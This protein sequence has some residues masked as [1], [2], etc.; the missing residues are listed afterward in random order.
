MYKVYLLKRNDT[1]DYD[2][3]DSC[4]VVAADPG[5]ALSVANKEYELFF[6]DNTEIEEIKLDKSK[7][8]LGNYYSS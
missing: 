2:E 7:P 8:I 4:V 6:E 1:I 3:Y 5:E